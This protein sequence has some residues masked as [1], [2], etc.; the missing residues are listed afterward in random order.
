[1]FTKELKTNVNG[2]LCDLMSGQPLLENYVSV[3]QKIEFQKYLRKRDEYRNYIHSI[4]R[5]EKPLGYWEKVIVNVA[6][7]IFKKVPRGSARAFLTRLV[8]DWHYTG[9]NKCKGQVSLTNASCQLCGAICEDQ[10]HISWHCSHESMIAVRALHTQQINIDSKLVN[11]ATPLGKFTIALNKILMTPKNYALLVGRVHEE[12]QVQLSQLPLPK[13]NNGYDAQYQ[14]Y[15]S[16]VRKYAN[17]IMCLYKTRQDILEG[18]TTHAARQL[19]L[20][21]ETL[22]GITGNK[23]ITQDG[24]K[25]NSI[26]NT[27]TNPVAPSHKRTKLTTANSAYLRIQQAY[28]INKYDIQEKREAKNKIT[29]AITR[30]DEHQWDEKYEEID[31]LQISYNTKT[32]ETKKYQL[33]GYT[34]GLTKTKQSK[35]KSI[36]NSKLRLT[37]KSTKMNNSSNMEGTTHVHIG[38]LDNNNLSNSVTSESNEL[39]Y[40]PIWHN[41]S[42]AS[43]SIVFLLKMLILSLPLQHQVSAINQLDLTFSN[44]LNNITVQNSSTWIP[45]I[46]NIRDIVYSG[47]QSLLRGFPISLLLVLDKLMHLHTTMTSSTI[48]TCLTRKTHY[49]NNNH[50]TIKQT[51]LKNTIRV[52]SPL[53]HQ[54]LESL[55]EENIENSPRQPSKCQNCKEVHHRYT[56]QIQLPK[57]LLIDFALI[58]DNPHHHINIPLTI[59]IHNK[60]I[61]HIKAVTYASSNHF[62][63][64]IQHNNNIWSYDGMR[65]NGRATMCHNI[66]KIMLTILHLL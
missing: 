9:I 51:Q 22:M 40:G 2:T 59:E 36:N 28:R 19:I 12:H 21:G 49:C 55:I 26:V 45:H 61:Y 58:T 13:K 35:S 24:T 6:G 4:R 42:C 29:A 31:K 18:K 43:D 38:E 54:T 53:I 11:S 30:E 50:S 8:W 48:F 33:G 47:E 56:I 16:L 17:M 5:V 34:P 52:I 10:E 64:R 57:I 23:F 32:S 41:M 14:T 66:L 46:E 7:D 62:V 27:D 15:I 20:G 1:M 37:Q 39:L 65:D 60:S 25:I 44:L 63:Q 3:H